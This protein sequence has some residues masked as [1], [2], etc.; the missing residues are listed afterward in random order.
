MKATGDGES[1]GSHAAATYKGLRSRRS[2]GTMSDINVTPLVDVVLVL[3]LIFMV[4]APMMTTG[5]DVDLPVASRSDDDNPEDR[6]TVSVDARGRIFV[7]KQPVNIALLEEYLR[8]QLIR[9]TQKVAY[10]NADQSLQYGQVIAVIDKM[11]KAGVERI[12]FA[13]EPPKE[14]TGS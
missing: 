14:G 10:I 12:G 6:I 4:T 5:I 13:Y 9:Q 8:D 11:R 7:A 1:G 3:L 2:V